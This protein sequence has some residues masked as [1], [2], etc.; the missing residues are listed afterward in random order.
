LPRR[1]RPQKSQLAVLRTPER[2]AGAPALVRSQPRPSGAAIAAGK[3]S[4]LANTG[5]AAVPAAAAAAPSSASTTRRVAL[6]EAEEPH[7]EP[8]VDQWLVERG[9]AEQRDGGLVAT[10][11]GRELAAVFDE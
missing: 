1:R 5:A 7:P 10:D 4:Q 2:R 3:Q 11:A 6:A 8:S 9:L